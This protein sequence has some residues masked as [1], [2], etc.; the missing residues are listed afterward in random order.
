M[1]LVLLILN[2]EWSGSEDQY[3]LYLSLGTK[4][5]ATLGFD[6]NVEQSWSYS[7]GDGWQACVTGR[8]MNHGEKKQ[9]SSGFCGYNWMVNSIVSYNEIKTK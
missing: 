4:T 8:V 9:K 5:L 2:L 7:F 1:R 3:L 6:T